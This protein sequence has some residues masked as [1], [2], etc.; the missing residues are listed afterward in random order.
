VVRV[1]LAAGDDPRE[2]R[3]QR[4]L[5]A[6]GHEVIREAARAEELLAS[7]EAAGHLHAAAVSQ[8]SLGRR[9]PRL[10]RQL[11]KQAPHL[12][13]VLLLGPKA[14]RAWRLAI[15]AG[16]FE[17]VPAGAPEEAAVQAVGRALAYAVG[18]VV[19]E[20]SL[21]AAS[22]GKDRSIPQDLEQDIAVKTRS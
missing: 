15:L 6:T 7:I 22:G 18:R 10:L 8:G 19:G 9:W 12:P 21:E 4:I 11:R 17:A 20:L 3:M 13:V 16:A 14:D 5:E 1:L 2:G